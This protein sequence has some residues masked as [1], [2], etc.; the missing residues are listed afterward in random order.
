MVP[1]RESPELVY[2][3]KRTISSFNGLAC[4]AVSQLGNGKGGGNEEGEERE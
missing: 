4:L 1:L 2:G 3:G